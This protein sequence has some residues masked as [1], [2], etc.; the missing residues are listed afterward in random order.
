MKYYITYYLIILNIILFML[1][2]IGLDVDPFMFSREAFYAGSYYLAIT[3]MFFHASVLHLLLNMLAVL[4]FGMPIEKEFGIPVLLGVYF[5]TGFL[6]AILFSLTSPLP[7]IGASGAAFGLLSFLAFTK[8]FKFSIFPFIIPLPISVIAIIY[9]IST[10][11]VLNQPST[12]GH[13]AHL[14]GITAGTLLAFTFFPQQAKSGLLVIA[15]MT[16]TL[17]LL[18]IFL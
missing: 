13:W 10:I 2:I 6:A 3:H 9:T 1:P 17:L 5:T 4:A 7:A 14:G 16:L 18:P 15:I 8:P 12:V 11:L